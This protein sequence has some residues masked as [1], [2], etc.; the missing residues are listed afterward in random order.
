MSV[1][2]LKAQVYGAVVMALGFEGIQQALP[3]FAPRQA[4][5]AILTGVSAEYMDVLEQ[6]VGR[7]ISKRQDLL[8]HDGIGETPLDE[9]IAEVVHVDELRCGGLK[10]GI[11]NGAAQLRQ[12]ARAQAGK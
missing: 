2:H 3:P 7:A 4:A 12:R 8:I 11:Q 9:Q 5:L 10:A 6:L 1:G